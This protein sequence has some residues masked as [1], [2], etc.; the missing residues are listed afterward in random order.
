TNIDYN[1]KGQ[2]T[3]IHYASDAETRYAYDKDTFRLIHL[4]TRRGGTALQDLR[5][6]YD[7][8]GNITHIRDDAQQTIY[9]RNQRVEPS[10]EYTYDAIYRLI[11]ATGREHLGQVGGQ[12]NPPTAPDALNG[13]HSRL[14][15]PGDGTA[16]GT[17]VERYLY[18]A[19][20]NIL[21]MQHRGSDPVHPG[22]TRTYDYGD[23]SLI[24]DGTGG[25]LL[26]TSNRLSSTTIGG[27]TETYSTGG[28]GYDG[29]GNML[30]MPHLP[31]LQW[32]YRDQLQAT[33][34][35]VVTNG[36]T[37]ETTWYVY[38]A[39]GQRVRKVTERQTAAGQTP[40]R[41]KERVYLGGFEV[42]RE[43]END[44]ATIE[45]ERETLHMMDDK[46]RIALVETR[47]QGNDGS[48]V[49]LIRYQL[50]NHLGSA[51]L[52]LDD[53][54]HMISYEEYYPYGSTSYQA[55]RSGV[56][57]SANRY[58]YTGKERDEESGLYYHGARYYAPWLGRWTAFD[59]AWPTEGTEFT[60]SKN[61]PINYF[62]PDGRQPQ[63]KG[64]YSKQ[65]PVL[66]TERSG[67]IEITDEHKDKLRQFNKLL[68]EQIQI[69][70]K[71]QGR[72]ID[73]RFLI[74]LAEWTLEQTGQSS[75]YNPRGANVYN[76][77]GN[78]Q[79]QKTF[80]RPGNTEV[81]NGEKVPRPAHFRDFTSG[82]KT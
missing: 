80:P 45:L 8:A 56:E 47:T 67:E 73:L 33:A 6:T 42:Y 82:P 14:A 34:Q 28:D 60:Y 2:R 61:N 43:Y 39:G 40:T 24:E 68:T 55:V 17:Y 78:P 41:I 53:A 10:A 20:G 4:N 18:D 27:T 30:R 74:L 29:H 16:M 54:G 44:G 75:F 79:T 69:Q 59:P 15:Q 49:Q 12:P 19:V 1:A 26:K 63:I 52:E 22:W 31:L 50:G 46:Q 25:T 64:A 76:I 72:D 9:F 36:G 48:P 66:Y 3:L 57:V 7:P 21:A 5:Y 37:P 81:I 11:E 65:S 71:S 32:D 23:T 77:M 51:S 58:R 13:F 35:Q 38:D 62:D 70:D